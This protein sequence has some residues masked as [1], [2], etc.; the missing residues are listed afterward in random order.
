L[1]QPLQVF[2]TYRFSLFDCEDSLFNGSQGY[3]RRLEVGDMGH[4]SNAPGFERSGHFS[5]PCYEHTLIILAI[6]PNLVK[7]DGLT[8]KGYNSEDKIIQLPG[9][10]TGKLVKSGGEGLF[11]S[12]SRS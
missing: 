11:V 1:L 10:E 8:S 7:R 6:G 3:P 4:E 12:G 5:L 9:V 2:E